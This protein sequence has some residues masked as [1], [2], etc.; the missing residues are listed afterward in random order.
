MI[1]KHRDAIKYCYDK[2]L[3]KRRDLHGKIVVSF[4]IA[5]NGAVVKASIKES[6]MGSK[7][8]VS[9]VVSRVKRFRFPA[10]K[11]GGIV[12]VSYPFIFKAS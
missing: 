2:E 3:Q 12:E 8:V 6:S 4:V 1:N 9:C 7:P 5:P 10:P 11:G